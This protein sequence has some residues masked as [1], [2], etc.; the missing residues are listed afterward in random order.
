M[1]RL[2]WKY[3]RLGAFRFIC[4]S[5]FRICVFVLLLF[6]SALK[7]AC[8]LGA[9]E[10]S[11]P[12]RT[13]IVQD[14]LTSGSG[15]VY[16]DPR[17]QNYTQLIE[18]PE[19]KSLYVVANGNTL[20]R[21]HSEDLRHLASFSLPSKPSVS[22]CSGNP[23]APCEEHAAFNL[24]SKTRDGQNLWY[25][26]V[27]QT[28]YMK[29][30]IIPNVDSARCEI[31][32]PTT[33][34]P[35]A[36]LVQWENSVY[37]SLDLRKP[38]VYL[39]ASDGFLYTSGWFHGALHI[40]RVLLPNFNG[41]PNW[42][43]FLTTPDS[44][45]FIRG[46]F[47]LKESILSCPFPM[48]QPEFPFYNKTPYTTT[49]KRQNTQTEPATFIAVFETDE[50]VY[51]LFRESQPQSCPLKVLSHPS[52]QASFPRKTVPVQEANEG[53]NAKYQTTVTRLARV[54]KG[55]RGGYVYVN[56]GEFVTFAK[57]TVECT[58]RNH[59]PNNS[60]G[61][62]DE[63]YAYTH[64]ESA[65]WDPIDE[66]LYVI[67]GTS[68]GHPK[69]VAL[70][71]YTK[72]SI[73]EA[74]Q[75]DLL[76]S[77]NTDDSNP[78]KT[79][80]NPFPNICSRFSSKALSEM[81]L[82]QGRRLS[83]GHLLRTK[84]IQSIGNRPI[85]VRPAVGQPAR[86]TDTKVWKYLAL[87]H[88]GAHIVLYLATDVYVERYRIKSNGRS[89]SS[90]E[91]YACPIDRFQVGDADP[92]QESITGLH[93]IKR[94]PSS[95]FYILTTKHVIR[96]SVSE[97][98]CSGHTSRVSCL[99]ARNP[100]CVWDSNTGLCEMTTF[101]GAD[102][103]G[104]KSSPSESDQDK[105]RSDYSCDPQSLWDENRSQPDW[106]TLLTLVSLNGRD[107]RPVAALPCAQLATSPNADGSQQNLTCWCRPCR[108]CR[109]LSRPV[110]EIINC[111]VRPAWSPWS[112]W[113]ACSTSCGTGVR[114]RTRRCD[115]P[116]PMLIPL[117]NGTYVQLN[118][119]SE[120][121]SSVTPSQREMQ[122]EQCTLQPICSEGSSRSGEKAITI[123]RSGIVQWDDAL[124][125]WTPWSNCSSHCGFGVRKRYMKCLL[126]NN[127]TAQRT[128]TCTV[129]GP[130]SRESQLCQERT[131]SLI[132]VQT[133][134]TDWFLPP[135]KHS[136][137]PLDVN[138]VHLRQRL[139]FVCHAP[140]I[141]TR[142]LRI[143]RV[144]FMERRCA[145]WNGA[146][147][148]VSAC[149][150]NQSLNSRLS[151]NTIA[152]G[153][154]DTDQWSSSSVNQ[155]PSS[156]AS[157][158]LASSAGVGHWSNWGPWSPCNQACLPPVSVTA[159][160][161]HVVPV[162]P[163]SAPLYLHGGVQTRRRTCLLTS[164]HDCPG[165]PS[166]ANESRPCPP[167]PA[168]HTDWSCWS[169]WSTCQ[170]RPTERGG[171]LLYP[172]VA[173]SETRRCE[174]KTDGMRK[175]VRQCVLGQGDWLAN[176]P[177]SCSG[178]I[179][180]TES[181]PR[182][183][184][185]GT[186]VCPPE[187]KVLWSA[188][189]Q[190]SSCEESIIL[191]PR[192]GTNHILVP[193]Q[194][195]P[196]IL[197]SRT[198]RCISPMGSVHSRPYPVGTE[199]CEG[200]WKQIQT[201]PIGAIRMLSATNA[202]LVTEKYPSRFGVSQLLLIGFLS[203]LIVAL[204]VTLFLIILHFTQ[205]RSNGTRR[206]LIKRASNVYDQAEGSGSEFEFDRNGG[207]KHHNPVKMPPLNVTGP[208]QPLL[209]LPIP[210]KKEIMDSRANRK[211][212]GPACTPQ[213]VYDSVASQDLPT[214]LR[215]TEN[216]FQTS[217]DPHQDTKRT[218]PADSRARTYWSLPRRQHDTAPSHHLDQCKTRDYIND[219]RFH[220]YPR[221]SRIVDSCNSTELAPTTHSQAQRPSPRRRSE[222]SVSEDIEPENTQSIRLA[223]HD[224]REKLKTTRSTSR[225][226]TGQLSQDGRG[227]S[228]RT[229]P[230]QTDPLQ[231]LFPEDNESFGQISSSSKLSEQSNSS[232]S[233]MPPSMPLLP[234]RY[235]TGNRTS[236]HSQ[237]ATGASLCSSLDWAPETSSGRSDIYS[238]C[239]ERPQNPHLRDPSSQRP[240]PTERGHGVHSS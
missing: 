4:E 80:P 62:P 167:V 233:C 197:R 70:C 185:R 194:R 225:K 135:T 15:T 172:D 102:R 211:R 190:W 220:S 186:H 232:T 130:E 213:V 54:C 16:Y 79:I 147:S 101:V 2:H 82:D 38:G 9:Q 182:L 142:D 17:I 53:S 125:V 210:V 240:S 20:I 50:E 157:F 180:E 189:S 33:L 71:I 119:K 216:P 150:M 214:S 168:C 98:K 136:H 100:Y 76:S 195:Q 60:T 49:P 198:R 7:T 230:K 87:D 29:N 226:F 45:N 193:D 200:L 31:P 96:L 93:L 120:I 48:K 173:I 35:G 28:S 51:F 217:T 83:Q 178:P 123:Q 143:G 192:V 175:R 32:S 156:A 169:D 208:P 141:T 134:F 115:S 109:E 202:M 221:R 138:K 67:Y 206:K 113:S 18:L 235:P 122:L 46:K 108:D 174:W 92:D 124:L 126:T 27:Y 24:L 149:F 160:V 44:P 158:G 78:T 116:G 177:P 127:E 238:I 11:D 179:D 215:L 40:H 111:T 227:R 114:T 133:K 110:L 187:Q 47:C 41:L 128:E 99:A 1:S 137:D 94:F 184:G 152:Q 56:E 204:L 153:I 91:L 181:C 69:G 140:S 159:V 176:R 65:T 72:Q 14:L 164:V 105:V 90:N 196:V 131:C 162:T 191:R 12:G 61:L 86:G 6:G 19:T 151:L 95:E 207:S 218:Y 59:F 3:M 34:E 219:E 37:S 10:T 25:C 42:D 8:E 107:E 145:P 5:A 203:F 212:F 171:L 231:P 52:E 170:A 148:P 23:E 30:T 237:S 26:Y 36:S 121:T 117:P 165:G 64:A 166:Q 39:M 229:G 89:I 84:T 155:P 68:S 103:Q 144:Q 106:W 85:L 146:C 43:Q 81:E 201:C 88:V 224:D 139:Q 112:P 222:S 161:N 21:L 75:S 58:L 97:T 199:V 66:Q 118:C 205:C 77:Q 104:S 55:D 239:L 129:I 57:A 163:Y 63:E 223:S 236:E 22:L 13:W 209:T 183:A 188:W 234:V 154:S 73:T 74:F 132:K 228:D